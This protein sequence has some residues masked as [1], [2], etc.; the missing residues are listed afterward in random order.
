M[1]KYIFL[2]LILLLAITLPLIG[3]LNLPNT[4]EAFSN[5]TLEEA[6]GDYPLS[7]NNVLVQDSY[8]IINKNTV[9]KDTAN[10]MWWHYPTF[11]VGSYD[12]ITNN[13]RYSNNPDVGRCT[14]AEFCAALYKEK[15]L[16]SNYTYPLPPISQ[17]NGTRIG[18]FMA[19]TNVN[20]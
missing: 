20:S 13:I 2:L 1:N 18:Y 5:Y 11:E 7:E 15:Q 9:S 10:K 14:P 16:K 4:L 8:P 6:S 17:I 3:N 19:N 12:Q